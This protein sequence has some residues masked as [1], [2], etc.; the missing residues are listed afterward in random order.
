MSKTETSSTTDNQFGRTDRKGRIIDPI[1][2]KPL[3]NKDG[4]TGAGQPFHGKPGKPNRKAEKRLAARQANY[5]EMVKRNNSNRGNKHDI[6]K[7]G[8]LTK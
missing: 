8:S 2:G 6:H 7:P 5:D 1:T 4:R 3:R